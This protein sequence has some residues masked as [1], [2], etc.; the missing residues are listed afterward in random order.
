MCV[1]GEALV[2]E[3]G[4]PGTEGFL[5]T[6]TCANGIDDDCDGATDGADGDCIP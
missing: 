2:C 5:A 3:P 4:A 6:G 1:D